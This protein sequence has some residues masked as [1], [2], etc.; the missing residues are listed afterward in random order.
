MRSEV[1][2]KVTAP[3]AV[4]SNPSPKTGVPVT[5]D[6]WFPAGPE[7]RRSPFRVQWETRPACKE[8]A[9][10]TK[11]PAKDHDFISYSLFSPAARRR[12]QPLAAG[13]LAARVGAA[14]QPIRRVVQPA[15]SSPRRR[16]S[17]P[18]QELIAQTVNGI[19]DLDL[20]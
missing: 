7:S 5:K 14:A 6:P 10:V 2:L 16:R 15:D 9:T 19:G 1:P 18:S 17:R 4:P 11:A 3:P 13:L 12:P 20:A 8:A